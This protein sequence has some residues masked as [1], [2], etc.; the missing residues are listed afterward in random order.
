MDIGVITVNDSA[1]HPNR[2]LLEAAG[3]KGVRLGLINPYELSP[4]IGSNGLFM[5]DLSHRRMPRVILPR[6]GAQIGESSL[7]MLRQMADRKSTR[8]NSSH[9]SLS[10]M[11]S[12]A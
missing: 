10:R 2:R 5:G 12:S 9:R 7:T 6:Q 8:L 1:Y 3:E 11:P 4:G